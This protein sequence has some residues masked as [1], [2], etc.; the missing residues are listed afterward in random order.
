MTYNPA[1][2]A[3]RG[4][5]VLRALA[6]TTALA[7]LAVPAY[8]QNNASDT[9]KLI[10]VLQLKPGQIVAEIGA[11][12]GEL[13]VAIAKHVAPG[14]VYTS[15]LGG[16]RLSKLR[17]VVEK[18]ALTNIAVID[19]HEA[20]AN[21]AEGCCDAV[22][23]RNVYHH[24]ADPATMN[25]SIFRA[26]K[27]GA[28]IAVIDFAPRNSAPIGPPGKRGDNAAHGVSTEVVAAE[29]KAAGFQVVSTEDRGERW[30]LVVS[31][32]PHH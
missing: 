18:S 16:E 4:G 25:A 27:P 31:T 14:R 15:E 19:G 8:G 2:S 21:L 32:K 5:R 20:H 13:T 28:R 24:F 26:L 29:L 9:A 22:F 7:M 23:M 11:G 10:D 12:G 30:F 6:A 1:Q 17:N 3:A